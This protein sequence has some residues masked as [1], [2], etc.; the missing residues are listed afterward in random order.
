MVETKFFLILIWTLAFQAVSLFGNMSDE[1]TIITCAFIGTISSILFNLEFIKKS[2][3]TGIG[4][5]LLSFVLPVISLQTLLNYYPSMVKGGTFVAVLLGLVSFETIKTYKENQTNY[6]KRLF[7][8]VV[9]RI[10]KRIAGKKIEE[11]EG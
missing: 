8:A 1:V 6:I 4:I 2:K 3:P 10:E 7:N 9:S 5:A 11:S